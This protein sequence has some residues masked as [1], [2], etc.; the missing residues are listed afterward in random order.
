MQDW[1]ED[2][3]IE[4]EANAAEAKTKNEQMTALQRAHSARNTLE[5]FEGA[6]Q[7]LEDYGESEFMASVGQSIA[8]SE[9]TN[10]DDPA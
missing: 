5:V 7:R 9:F 2:Y 3:L 4:K 8:R 1:L 10:S 6:A